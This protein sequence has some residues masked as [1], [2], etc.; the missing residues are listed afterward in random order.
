MCRWPA[1]W[2]ALSMPVS[3]SPRQRL[4]LSPQ[5]APWLRPTSRIADN[6]DTRRTH[7][8]ESD[9]CR[10]VARSRRICEVSLSEQAY[11][12]WAACK[13][14]SFY[15]MSLDSWAS[16]VM[17]QLTQHHQRC[18]LRLG[19]LPHLGTAAVMVPHPGAY[20]LTLS[21][22]VWLGIHI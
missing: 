18:C 17:L 14:P 20:I 12:L 5:E 4:R 22:T 21:P 19:L 10:T 16:D 15:D 11:V 8:T 9:R 13:I 2:L 3:A 7:A 6:S 1:A